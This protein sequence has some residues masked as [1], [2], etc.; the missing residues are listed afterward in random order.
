MTTSPPEPTTVYWGTVGQGAEAPAEPSGEPGRGRVGVVLATV[1]AV[2]G[3]AAVGSLLLVGDNGPGPREVAQGYV[4]ALQRLD[5][6][7]VAD[8]SLD[9]ASSGAECRRLSRRAIYRDGQFDVSRQ[10]RES[11]FTVTGVDEGPRRADVDVTIAYA[12]ETRPASIS[13]VRDDDARWRVDDLR[14]T[15]SRR[16]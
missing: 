5:C 6:A 10:I 15:G 12:G 1:L 2:F 11:R 14:V 16:F 7:E 3:V 4:T 13:L 8:L 9:S